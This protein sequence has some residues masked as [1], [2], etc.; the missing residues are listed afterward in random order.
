MQCVKIVENLKRERE[1]HSYGKISRDSLICLRQLHSCIEQASEIE[2]EE[3]HF[4][5]EVL[6]IHTRTR[7]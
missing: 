1:A 6:I 5:I 3:R 4:T 7:L 2:E